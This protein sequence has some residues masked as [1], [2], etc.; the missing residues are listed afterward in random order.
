[1]K[2]SAR[3]DAIAKLVAAA[4]DTRYALS[5]ALAYGE[6]TGGKRWLYNNAWNALSAALA[7]MRRTTGISMEQDS[8]TEAA[9]ARSQAPE[10][11]VY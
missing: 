3:E 4:E 5:L 7:A 11:N 1:M 10:P 6:T 2:P 9:D 8:H